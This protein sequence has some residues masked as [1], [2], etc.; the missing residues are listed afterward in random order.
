MKI[1]QVVE[2]WIPW[3]IGQKIVGDTHIPQDTEKRPTRRLAEIHR[4]NDQAVRIRDAIVSGHFAPANEPCRLRGSDCRKILH[5]R[6]WRIEEEAIETDGRSVR[7][8]PAR[9]GCRRPSGGNC[10]DADP[11]RTTA[12]QWTSPF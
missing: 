11:H 10:A 3:V 4:T 5:E 12:V 2:G 6:V 1:A 8:L 9:D 7:V